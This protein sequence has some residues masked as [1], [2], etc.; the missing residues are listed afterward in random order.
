V[1]YATGTGTGAVERRVA[2]LALRPSIAAT[3]TARRVGAS[4]TALT[5]RGRLTPAP[6][7]AL[8][9]SWQARPAGG[10]AWQAFCRDADGIRVAPDGRF[11]GRCR[12]PL[13]LFAGNRYRLVL[14]VQPQTPWARAVSP[15]RRAVAR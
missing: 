1:R 9:L 8:R 6:G 10:G 13:R 3:F 5:V 4:L 7:V 12:L 2:R 11:S 15:A 14:P